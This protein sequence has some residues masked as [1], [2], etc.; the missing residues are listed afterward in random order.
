MAKSRILHVLCPYFQE[1]W[2]SRVS[3]RSKNY[4]KIQGAID[5]FNAASEPVEVADEAGKSLKSC[6]SRW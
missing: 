3:M 5:N 1:R 6:Q 4:F 2:V